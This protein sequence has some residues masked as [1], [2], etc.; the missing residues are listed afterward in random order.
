MGRQ[1]VNYAK[2]HREFYRDPS[3]WPG[4]DPNHK[5]YLRKLFNS[6]IHGVLLRLEG[7][8]GVWQWL[9]FNTLSNFSKLLDHVPKELSRALNRIAEFW[10]GICRHPSQIL[11]DTITDGEIKGL[12]PAYSSY[13]MKKFRNA[14]AN[15]ADRIFPNITDPEER[16][17]IKNKVEVLNYRVPSLWIAKSEARALQGIV[18]CL[19]MAL[20]NHKAVLKD[21]AILL[22]ENKTSDLQY[23]L[24]FLAAARACHHMDDSVLHKEVGSILYGKESYT[25]AIETKATF[26][27]S[28]DKRVVSA[29]GHGVWK[30]NDMS[31]GFHFETLRDFELRAKNSQLPILL[32]LKDFFESFFGSVQEIKYSKACSLVVAEGY[33]SGE[34]S[35]SSE[36]SES[37]PLKTPNSST[38]SPESIISSLDLS[39]ITEMAGTESGQVSDKDTL[40]SGDD[41]SLRTMDP[42]SRVKANQ[43]NNDAWNS[44]SQL[45]QSEKFH[46][47]DDGEDSE[48]LESSWGPEPRDDAVEIEETR[49]WSDAKDGK[50]FERSNYDTPSHNAVTSGVV[51]IFGSNNRR[52]SKV[53]KVSIEVESFSQADRS[54]RVYS[55][56]ALKRGVQNL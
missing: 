32:L 8:P 37:E 6:P 41:Q 13:D 47:S 31:A 43:L 28:T 55:K 2:L 1:P 42:K 20:S 4:L 9:N 33:L 16:D 48:F 19:Q 18:D 11:A 10:E 7:I 40:Y 34:Y 46:S 49:L 50:D 17:C 3:G 39:R 29:Q 24:C 52:I 53:L 5:A 25:A 14:M 38:N 51:D 30:C 22:E 56:A 21:S 36:R 35:S 12:W 44:S 54:L 23:Y 26:R 27:Q 45:E 15:K